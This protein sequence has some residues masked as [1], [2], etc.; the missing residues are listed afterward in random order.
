M[1]FLDSSYIKGLIIKKDSYK[2]F[3]NNIRPL[4]K[5]ETK[6][7]N[8]TVIVEVL[9]SLKKNNYEGSIEEIIGE[10]CN[11]DI[12]D[13]M[14]KEDYKAAMEKFKFYNG[15]INF[16]DCTILVT[17]QKHGINKIVTTDS[18]F[19]KINGLNRISIGF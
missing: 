19:E 6:V 8:I 2:E 9:N 13:W 18:D 5:S 1:I 3:S 7:I 17:M 14:T 16:A 12:V 10:L 4:L 11:V 15:A